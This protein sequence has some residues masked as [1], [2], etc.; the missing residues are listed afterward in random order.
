[1]KK[2]ILKKKGFFVGDKE[3]KG[4]AGGNPFLD[5]VERFFDTRLGPNGC[6][7]DQKFQQKI[8]QTI[9][10]RFDRVIIK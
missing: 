4:E 7:S 5:N 8:N 3:P 9:S 1:M 2:S 10:G 6:R